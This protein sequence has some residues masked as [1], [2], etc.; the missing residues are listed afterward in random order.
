M[1]N[2]D[3]L[4]N[5]IKSLVAMISKLNIVEKDL[6][7]WI[8]SGVTRHTCKNMDFFKFLKEVDDE[9]FVVYLGNA[10]IAAIIEVGEV[11]LKFTSGHIVTLTNLLFV[12]EVRKI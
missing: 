9:Q 6:S 12:L 5:E 3:S 11:N 8:D 10:V 2:P 1:E 7:W 4:N